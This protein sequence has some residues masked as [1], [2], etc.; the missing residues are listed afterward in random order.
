MPQLESDS[1]S[2]EPRSSSRKSAHPRGA[3]VSGRRFVIP[4]VIGL[5]LLLALTLSIALQFRSI[6][7]Q[8]DESRSQWPAA[9]ADFAA[10][11]ASTNRAILGR[12]SNDPI[13]AMREWSFV[14]QSFLRTTQYDRQLP[15]VLRLEEMIRQVDASDA[16][17]RDLQVDVEV[18]RT[19]A[20]TK[21]L[22]SE[23]KRTEYEQ[24][25]LGRLTMACLRLKLQEPFPQPK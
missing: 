21:W 18:P 24:S 9:S 14:Y 3:T 23:R 8:L 12:Q 1:Q 17:K 6:M 25:W 7:K 20:V 2:I 22:E 4:F 13:P 19:R 11:Y 15:H 10:R 16:A 5:I